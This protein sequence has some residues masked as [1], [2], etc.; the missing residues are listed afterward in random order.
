M[1]FE[2]YYNQLKK[3]KNN[4]SYWL[5]KVADCGIEIP[6]TKIFDVPQDVVEQFAYVDDSKKRQE[7]FDTIYNW[8]KENVIPYLPRELTNLCFIKNGAFSNKFDFKTCASVGNAL[9]ITKSL[10]EINYMSLM[11]DTGGLTEIAIR[12][13]IHYNHEITPCIYNGMPL[14]NEYR[15]FYDFDNK[16]PLYIVNYWD[17]DYCYETISRELTDKIIYE[18]AYPKLQ[19][20]YENNKDKV[21]Q[22]VHEHM[23]NVQ[24]LNGIW[25]VD[26]LEDRNNKY[27]LIDMAEGYRSAYW[28]PDKVKECAE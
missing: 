2:N 25:S 27:W 7:A 24:G 1:S 28:N 6:L 4:M 8:V 13:R 16:K 14:Q 18:Y 10:V 3:S 12:E 5:P 9:E 19:E 23:Q 22:F 21:M 15:I 11:F 17:W 26:I 20:N